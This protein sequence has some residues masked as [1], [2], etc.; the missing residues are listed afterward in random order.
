MSL[1]RVHFK[2]K[3]KEVELSARKLDLTHPYFVSIKDLVFDSKPRL[4]IDPS[5]DEVLKTFG[6]AHHLMIPF[7]TVSLI[8]EISENKEAPEKKVMPFTLVENNEPKEDKNRPE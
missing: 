5:L 8:E 2:W 7:Q 1:Y 4:I 3:E 6:S